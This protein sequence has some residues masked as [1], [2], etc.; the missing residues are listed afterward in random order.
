MQ[1]SP[2]GQP[3]SIAA[4]AHSSQFQ[5]LGQRRFAP[6]FWT[7]FLGVANDNIFRFA[8]IMLVTNQLVHT[9]WLTPLQVGSIVSAVF[10]LPF[11]LFSAT[12]GQLTDKYD[13]TLIVRAVKNL[14]IAIALIAAWGFVQHA[15]MALLSP[16]CWGNWRARF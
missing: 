8:F 13:K 11:L 7:Q 14:E 16:F 1:D 3:E 6:F 9:A 12:A 15:P 5:L 2:S 4:P 10:V